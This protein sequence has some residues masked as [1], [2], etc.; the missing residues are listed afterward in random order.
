MIL[1]LYQLSYAAVPCSKGGRRTLRNARTR[2]KEPYG[3]SAGLRMRVSACSTK[4][5]T[6]CRVGQQS[7]SFGA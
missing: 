3:C 5:S 1:L 6:S 2:I 4:V 7:G